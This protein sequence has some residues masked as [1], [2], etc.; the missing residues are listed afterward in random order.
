MVG[1]IRDTETA[2]LAI[3]AA[4]TGHQVFSTVH[5]NSAAGSPPR[6]LDMGVEPFLLT[7]A[8]N[9]VV[10]QRVV[11]KICPHCRAQYDAPL[12]VS[13]NIKKILGNFLPQSQSNIMRLY[14]GQG[15][16]FCSKTGYLGRVG[17]FEVLVISDLIA[18]LILE[19]ASSAAIEERAVSEG[20]I[21]MKQDGYMKVL[22]GVTTLE[23]V[24]RVAQD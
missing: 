7:S 10:G 2:D 9:A 13:E 1:E 12:E 17:I 16:S 15:C 8:L 22:E 20:M 3:Q 21:T 23:E 19:H 18:K 6:L 14:K 4:L 24:L 11:R 5:T